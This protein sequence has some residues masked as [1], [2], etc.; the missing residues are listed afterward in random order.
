MVADVIIAPQL[1]SSL[2]QLTAKEQARVIEFINI[3]QANPA[4]PGVSLERLT[5]VRSRNVWS[6]RISRDL[7]AILHKDGE[8]W[9][10]LYAAHH[11]PARM[12]GQVSDDMD[13]GEEQRSGTRSLLR[14]PAPRLVGHATPKDEIAAEARERRLLY[15][16]MTRARDELTVSWSGSPSR[17]LAPLLD[18]YRSAT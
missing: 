12:L 18:T 1:F 11:D 16:A 6:G 3:F 15:V 8:T 2:S 13:G 7:R 10:I 9:A 14:G 5:R 4:H 17:C